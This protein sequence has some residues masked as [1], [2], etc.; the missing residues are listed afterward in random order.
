MVAIPLNL[1]SDILYSSRLL[2]GSELDSVDEEKNNSKRFHVFSSVPDVIKSSL[3]GFQLS[4]LSSIL[5]LS[6]LLS[7]SPDIKSEMEGVYNSE[8][9]I[10]LSLVASVLARPMEPKISS[11]E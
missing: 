8:G 9:L 11:N 1:R 5:V 6:L 10:Q 7:P 3:S 4:E 2:S